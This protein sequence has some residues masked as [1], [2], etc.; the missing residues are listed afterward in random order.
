[1]KFKTDKGILKLNAEAVDQMIKYLQLDPKD[2]E[3]GGVLLGRFIIDSNDLVVDKVTAPM[4]GDKRTRYSF[5]R[6]A[7]RHQ[8]IIDEEWNATQGT[9]HYLGEWHTH[10][11]DNPEPSGIDKGNWIRH[12]KRDTFPNRYL[13]FLIAGRKEISVWEADRKKLKIKKLKKINK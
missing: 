11:E 3:A 7:K 6:G 2:T 5:E 4:R 1:M 10:P 12:L 9:C 8:Q 13:Y